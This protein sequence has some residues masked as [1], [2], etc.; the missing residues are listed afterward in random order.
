MS[1]SSSFEDD[2]QAYHDREE[3]KIDA[4]YDRRIQ[5]FLDD[6]DIPRWRKDR[7]LRRLRAAEDVD[8]G[9]IDFI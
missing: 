5:D 6:E 9:P 8:R 4:D 2:D 1:C 3:A 7:Y